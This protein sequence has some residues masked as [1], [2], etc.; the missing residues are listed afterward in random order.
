[1]VDRLEIVIREPG[2]PDHVQRLAEGVAT[3]GRAEDCTVLLSDAAISR[4]HAHIVVRNGA[5]EISDIGSGNGIFHRG[6]RVV[7]LAIQSEEEVTLGP[8]TLLFRLVSSKARTAERADGPYGIGAVQAR[9][10]VVAG[11]LSPRSVYH[12]DH[13]GLSIGRGEDQDLVL[14]DAMASRRHARLHW[15]DGA[16]RIVDET[17]SNGVFLNGAR[18]SDAVLRDGD[19]IRIGDAEFRFMAGDPTT[20]DSKTQLAFSGELGSQASERSVDPKWSVNGVRDAGH[21]PEPAADAALSDGRDV[22]GRNFG[23]LLSKSSEVHWVAAWSASVAVVVV[24]LAVLAGGFGSLAWLSVPTRPRGGA[25]PRFSLSASFDV[26]A[27]L[28]AREILAL[29]ADA[30]RRRDARAALEFSDAAMRTGPGQDAPQRLAFAAAEQVLVSFI[31]VQVGELKIPS[32]PVSEP[33]SSL[34]MQDAVRFAAELRWDAAVRAYERVLSVS[35]EPGTRRL[36][37]LGIAHA[38]GE[39]AR[40]IQMEWRNAH[41]ALSEGSRSLAVQH[42]ENVAAM[43]TSHPGARLWRKILVK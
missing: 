34:D 2:R 22:P 24:F 35:A 32:L 29:A 11:E 28:E 33:Y 20:T 1:M 30:V 9:L 39:L 16:W 27:R 15:L 26:G 31:D 12:A 19:R 36:A 40:D 23:S 14:F 3:V 13:R 41:A 7:V 8:Y 42:F 5:A 25:S 21:R 4:R 6:S 18:V 10:E 17:S 43:S 37:Q 38:R